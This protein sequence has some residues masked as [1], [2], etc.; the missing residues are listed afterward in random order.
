MGTIKTQIEWHEAI[1][2]SDQQAKRD[3]QQ[4]VEALEEFLT[5]KCDL[6]NSMDWLYYVDETGKTIEW[7]KEHANYSDPAGNLGTMLENAIIENDT[8]L[9]EL[10]YL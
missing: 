9:I 7:L 8:D 5:S 10:F 2:I 6:F 4:Q 1:R 3:Q